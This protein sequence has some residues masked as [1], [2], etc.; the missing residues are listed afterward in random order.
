MLECRWNRIVL[1]HTRLYLYLTLQSI[2]LIRLV[3]LTI[4]SFERNHHR[5]PNLSKLVFHYQPHPHAVYPRIEAGCVGVT[6]LL[7]KGAI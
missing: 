4:D 7:I 3:E 2:L 5:K 1:V 6:Q